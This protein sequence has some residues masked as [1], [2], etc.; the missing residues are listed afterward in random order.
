MGKK[1]EKKISVFLF[2]DFF[3]FLLHKKSR[4]KNPE[5]NLKKKS[6]FF[7]SKI[8]KKFLGSKSKNPPPLVFA[9]FC[10]LSRKKKEKS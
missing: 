6:E 2:S 7:F 1:S 10:F 5:K 8:R 3:P 9:K 4:Q